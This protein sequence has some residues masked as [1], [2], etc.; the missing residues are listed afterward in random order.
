MPNRKIKRNTNPP[1]TGVGDTRR[2][3]NKFPQVQQKSGEGVVL[4]GSSI[5]HNF[6]IRAMGGGGDQKRFYIPGNANALMNSATTHVARSYATGVFKPGTRIRW[7]PTCSPL[8]GGRVFVGFTDNPELMKVIN[9]LIE[10][11]YITP[12]PVSYTELSNAVKGLANM[13]SF[14]A[15]V[16]RE[17]EVP[18]RL[19][20]K[21]FNVN[22]LMSNYND[23]AELDR[24]A[25]LA[26]FAVADGFVGI[27]GDTVIGSFWFHDVLDLEGLHGQLAT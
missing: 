19:R 10:N 13:V 5:G 11:Y 20:H 24:S 2:G 7:E 4:R 27:T 26:M 15:Y 18:T 17:I 21:R 9:T 14:P 22:A 25:Q 3:R 8:S 6:V 16:E 23:I 12:D 1:V